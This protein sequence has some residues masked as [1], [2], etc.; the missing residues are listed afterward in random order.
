M[1]CRSICTSIHFTC[2]IY[3]PLLILILSSQNQSIYNTVA[4]S[5]VADCW[6][7]GLTIIFLCLTFCL[8]L[9]RVKVFGFSL[10]GLFPILLAITIT[11]SLGGILTATK[12]FD[13]DSKCSTA[14]SLEYTNA[15]PWFYFP[16]PFQ[17]GTPQFRSYA[18]VP[19]IGSMLASMV[20]VSVCY[21]SAYHVS[22]FV[23]TECILHFIL[24]HSR[25]V[26]TIRVQ[27]SLVPQYQPLVLSLEVLQ[28]KG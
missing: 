18:I 10:F 27:V 7:L 9:P 25:L 11:W 17:F 15:V 4:F 12:V 6:P 8:Y 13:S 23:T 24:Q 1:W 19:M 14:Q 20:E 16:Y 3:Y 28:P 5:G 21:K 26:I 22:F 2:T